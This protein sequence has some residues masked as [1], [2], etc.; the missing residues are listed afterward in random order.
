M[1]RRLSPL[2]VSLLASA[3]LLV[4]LAPSTVFG[5]TFKFSAEG[6]ILQSPPTY[7]GRVGS[8]A[9]GSL[10]FTFNDTGWPVEPEARFDHIWEAYFAPNYDTI[11]P[12]PHWDGQIP[13]VFYIETTSAPSGYAGWCHG[14]LHAKIVVIDWNRDGIP[15]E[16]EKWTPHLLDCRLSKLCD[17]GSGGEMACTW[18]WGAIATDSTGHFSFVLPPGSDRVSGI[19]NLNLLPGCPSPVEQTS[20]GSIKQLYR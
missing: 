2:G 16:N 17:H 18:G 6:N 14:D 7:T 12:I 20:W 8:T 10:D 11:G 1:R 9:V 4:A 13:G 5:W 19:G 3:V 15:D